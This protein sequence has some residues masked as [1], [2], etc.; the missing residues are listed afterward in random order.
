MIAVDVE[1]F[2]A[3]MSRDL[4]PTGPG[5]RPGG[6]FYGRVRI[7]TMTPE[8]ARPLYE[9]LFVTGYG[10][11]DEWVMV[12]TVAPPDATAANDAPR[13]WVAPGGCGP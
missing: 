12:S 10:A 4:D 11:R 1:V 7:G 8:Q 13:G 9:K 3:G 5:S 6:L 2:F